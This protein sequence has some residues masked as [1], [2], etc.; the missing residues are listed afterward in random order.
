[1][2]KNKS[3]DYSAILIKYVWAKRYI[4][5]KWSLITLY[6][7]LVFYSWLSNDEYI[8]AIASY[9]NQQS[10]YN[11]IYSSD[12]ILQN[13][14]EIQIIDSNCLFSYKNHTNR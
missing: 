6:D 12:V 9:Q 10:V 4:D 8:N 7:V 11:P 5:V 14:D 1:M 2:L 3:S 13:S